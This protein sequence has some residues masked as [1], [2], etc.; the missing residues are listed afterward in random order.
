MEEE[1]SCWSARTVGDMVGMIK[2]GSL[3]LL[4]RNRCVCFGLPFEGRCFLPTVPSICEEGPTRR[5]RDDDVRFEV[6]AQ[7]GKA[8]RNIFNFSWH[9][10]IHLYIASHSMAVERSARPLAQSLIQSGRIITLPLRPFT[11]SIPTR[12]EETTTETSNASPPPPPPK[13]K[14]RLDPLKVS[15]P[16]SERRLFRLQSQ[17]PI[18][19]RRRRAALASTTEIPFSQL[20][21]QCFQ[22]ARQFLAA[23]REA[24]LA[25]IRVQQQ[26]LERLRSK[27]IVDELEAAKRDKKL[28]DMRQRLEREKIWADIN[29]PMVKKRFE[30]GMGDMSKPIYRHL[31]N[32]K[33]RS[34]TR[35]IL[36]QR[37]EQMHVVPDLLPGIDPKISVSL[38]FPVK[39]TP[40]KRRKIPHGDMV[41]SVVSE[42]PPVLKVQSFEKGEK[43]YTIAIM[44]PDVPDVATDG[45]RSR[46]H[47]LAF[48]VPI[49]A[50]EALVKC[51][52][53]S[54][55]DQVV[56]PWL[57]AFSQ[58]GAPYQRMGIFV[59]EQPD[60]ETV[61]AG[62]GEVAKS[63]VVEVEKFMAAREGKYVDREG[64]ILR[65][66]VSALKLKPV[67]VDLFRTEYDAGTR[68]VMKRAGISGWDVEFKRKR[69]EPLP[70]K[71]LKEE[72]FR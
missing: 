49:S 71:R 11:T 27:V 45:F 37:I 43:L 23:D 52:Q 10:E 57:P 12:A 65:S 32:Q 4:N 7:F 61:P 69:V 46:C 58:Q 70:Y 6:G 13:P 25:E 31:A 36:L 44:T 59:M 60:A 30:D 26:R 22:E 24:R 42:M 56:H 53:L 17:L 62:S 33:W 14:R 19:S 5:A 50:H 15:T 38:S 64:F 18:G 3:M 39:S 8:S 55:D 35:E 41:E 40:W 68:G 2:D 34:Y 16:R 67:G 66:L 21:Y 28:Q 48:N 72:R 29:D 51:D 63:R 54:P 1:E 20:P 47:F 9:L